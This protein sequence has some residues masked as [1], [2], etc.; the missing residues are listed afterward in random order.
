M[1][2]E[3]T[4]KTSSGEHGVVSTA[5][6]EGTGKETFAQYLPALEAEWRE[7]RAFLPDG[8][9]ELN[10]FLFDELLPAMNLERGRISGPE[11]DNEMARIAGVGELTFKGLKH[12]VLRLKSG[13]SPSKL[14]DN[15]R[16]RAEQVPGG[17][18]SNIA[19]LPK[20]QEFELFRRD[21]LNLEYALAALGVKVRHNLRSSSHEWDVGDGCGWTPATDRLDD[22]LREQVATAFVMKDG[23][24]ALFG[25]ERWATSLNA[26]LYG[27]EVD[28]FIEWLEELP[29]WD[30]TERLSRWLPNAFQTADDAL[31]QWCSRFLFLGAVERAYRPGSKLDVM[32]VLVGPQ[33]C[34]K[35]S[36]LSLMFPDDRREW[37][38]DNLNLSADAKTRAE[39]LQGAVLV[40]V[41]EMTGSTRVELMALKAF[42]SRVDDSSR[43]AYR[44]NP[45]SMPRRCILVGTSNDE[46]CLP[47]DWTGN[48]RFLAV[49][50]E[51]RETGVAA[52]RKL[53][54][55]SRL[56]LWAEALAL[57]RDGV[58]ARLP[59]NLADAQARTNESHRAAD[60]ILEDL[61]DH[62]LSTLD[63]ASQFTLLQA[64]ATDAC[65]LVDHSGAVSPSNQ[66]KLG[67]LLTARGYSSKQETISGRRASW[68]RKL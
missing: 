53:M 6:I 15:K 63:E 62:W 57:H 26:M 21:K 29:S 32:P 27:L 42:L 47:N 28:S 24:P 22:N 46:K 66:R 51:P 18:G 19:V 13:P 33:G 11:L 38:T 16:Q 39:A 25:R 23:K 68:W 17:G 36:V 14:H 31:I 35:S 3:P 8:R 52:V 44:R 34:G 45:E 1:S 54:I 4:I 7:L 60:T 2:N 37:F 43:L 30:K 5:G 40:E 67:G 58:E 59:D 61:L 48:R 41:S 49:G 50:V 20:R 65:N 12:A 9:V 10:Q 64:A 56:Q 55:D